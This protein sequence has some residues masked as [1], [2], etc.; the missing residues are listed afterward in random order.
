MDVPALLKQIAAAA[1]QDELLFPTGSAASKLQ[2][3]LDDPDCSVAQLVPLVQADPLLA[4]RVVAVANSVAYHPSGRAIS[5][6]RSA[7][8]RLG[9][10]TL[11]V[12]AV[13]VVA[14]QLEGMAHG[15]AHRQMAARLWQ[16]TAHVAALARIIAR[17]VTR[18]DPESAFFAGIIH[19]LG[20]F[21]LISRAEGFPGLLSGKDGSLI[22][23]EEGGAAA[24]GAAVLSRLKVPAG[25]QAAIEGLWAGY[26]ALP[27]RTL[28][29]TLLLADQLAPVESPLSELAGT[30][31][32]GIATD[33]D[34]LLDDRTLSGILA[35]SA[36]EVA[37]LIEALRV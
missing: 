29:D 21:Y 20:G 11:R 9:F 10:D 26:I 16:H 1:A 17:R 14:R 6:V 34:L 32:E 13:A 22:A 5:D 28:A 37:S 15:G 18:V 8:S 31:R 12:L 4:A 36:A 25:I 24:V 35:E 19:E 3:L 2:R 33:I 27:P 30:G 7:V 23:W